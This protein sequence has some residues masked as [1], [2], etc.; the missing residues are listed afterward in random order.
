MR[1]SH[2]HA[3][4]RYVPFPRF[5]IELAPFGADKFGGTDKEQGKKAQ[6]AP[7]LK[8]SV[9]VVQPVQKHADFFSGND[10][11]PVPALMRT[12]G[13]AKIGGN[14]AR[15]SA[16]GN[17]VAENHAAILDDSVGDKLLSLSFKRLEYQ[18][19]VLRRDF[20]NGLPFQSG[21]KME[22]ER[23]QFPLPVF[24]GIVDCLRFMPFTDNM[25]EGIGFREEGGVFHLLFVPARINT[26][27][28][29]L[30]R[31]IPFCPGIF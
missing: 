22:L 2:L 25:L 26:V 1:L 29:Q 30:F 23:G 9:I 24:W 5:Q 3:F 11:G 10:G 14:V 8:V 28:K 16:C 12:Y 7:D 27:G 13:S 20:G 31:L 21:E 19:Q 4:G 17:G 18:Q 15:H 6:C